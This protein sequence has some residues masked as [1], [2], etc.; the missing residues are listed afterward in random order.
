[1]AEHAPRLGRRAVAAEGRRR[2]RSQRLVVLETNLDDMNPQHADLLRE[3]LFS[4]G[5]LDVWLTPIV[6]KKGRPAFTVSALCAQA[7]SRR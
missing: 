7:T 3:R 6:M 4:A 5:A 1:V 2:R